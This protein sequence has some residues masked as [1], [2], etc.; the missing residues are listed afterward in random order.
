MRELA[1]GEQR[2][3]VRLGGRCRS[4]GRPSAIVFGVRIRRNA[5]PSTRSTSARTP[6]ESGAGRRSGWTVHTAGLPASTGLNGSSGNLGRKTSEGGRGLRAVDAAAEAGGGDEEEDEEAIGW[7]EGAWAGAQGQRRGER[8]VGEEEV[9]KASSG[10]GFDDGPVCGRVYPTTS[11]KSKL[12]CRSAVRLPRPPRSAA[13]SAL[14][15]TS[16]PPTPSPPKPQCARAENKARK[17]PRRAR[18]SPAT[19]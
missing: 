17:G 8:R 12:D 2:R 4:T 5:Q 14:P 3:E 11:F 19:A 16:L 15:S 18:L 9:M 6:E 7:R 10:G 13:L 1:R